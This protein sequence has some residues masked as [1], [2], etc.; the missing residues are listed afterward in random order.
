MGPTQP[1]ILWEQGVVFLSGVKWTKREADYSLLASSEVN[2]CGSYI[3]ISSHVF[4]ARRFAIIHMDNFICTLPVISFLL[5]ANV[6]LSTL[7]A[8]TLSLRPS[9]D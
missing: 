5:D 1:H 7:F 8:N 9:V 2:K 6:H 3:S 4:M